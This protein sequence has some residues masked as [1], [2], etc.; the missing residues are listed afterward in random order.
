M[1]NKTTYDTNGNLTYSEECN[2]SYSKRTYNEQG[3]IIYDEGIGNKSLKPFWNKWD[4]YYNED[5]SKEIHFSDNSGYWYEE[6]FN[7]LGRCVDHVNSHLAKSKEVEFR[8]E[9]Y[10]YGKVLSV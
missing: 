4:R 9:Q 5:G 2:G 6:R 1:K 8:G 3:D 10:L 7:K